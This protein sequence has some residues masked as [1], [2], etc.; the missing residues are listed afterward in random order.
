MFSCYHPSVFPVFRVST[1]VLKEVFHPAHSTSR[2]SISHA[3][4]KPEDGIYRA[5]NIDVNRLLISFHV[6]SRGSTRGWST[7]TYQLI[8]HLSGFRVS[9]RVLR[10]GYSSCSDIIYHP[11][12]VSSS[13]AP[14]NACFVSC[15]LPAYMSCFRLS[16]SHACAK[17]GYRPHNIDIISRPPLVRY[18]SCR[19]MRVGFVFNTLLFQ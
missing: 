14:I 17:K 16:S 3:R 8:C 18:F 15:Y 9:S 5:P 10:R 4:T 2:L 11:P 13:F 7:V 6:H 1:R 19:S 12:S